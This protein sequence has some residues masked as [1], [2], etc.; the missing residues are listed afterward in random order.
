MFDIVTS[1]FFGAVIM[2]LVYSISLSANAPSE[3][4]KILLVLVLSS[5][6]M[7]IS[8][9]LGRRRIKHEKHTAY[10]RGVIYGRKLERAVIRS[11]IS[12]EEK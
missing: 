4:F 12:K 11:E 3:L 6:A 8:Y 7:I 9:C 2:G 1:F 5:A 10:T